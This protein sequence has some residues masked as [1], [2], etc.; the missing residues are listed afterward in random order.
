MSSGEAA[1]CA[2]AKPARCSE[3]A[4]Y[5]PAAACSSRRVAASAVPPCRAASRRVTT[6][7]ARCWSS[8]GSVLLPSKNS[9][10][11][12]ARAASRRRR[13]QKPRPKRVRKPMPYHWR[14]SRS[15]CLPAGQ[16]PIWNWRSAS[17]ARKSAARASSRRWHVQLA[18]TSRWSQSRAA[19]VPPASV[20]RSAWSELFSFN[21]RVSGSLRRQKGVVRG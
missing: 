13:A 5:Y 9:R 8:V 11:H 16:R 1:S 14:C 18:R 12:K 4:I 7:R 10:G 20:A 2:R 19:E 17:H 15:R 21:V 3:A 6:V